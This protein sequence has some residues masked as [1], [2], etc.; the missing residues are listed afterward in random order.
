MIVDPAFDKYVADK[1]RSA[2]GDDQTLRQGIKFNRDALAK[3]LPPQ[4]GALAAEALPS[5]PPSPVPPRLD[6][7]QSVV[8]PPDMAKSLP[9]GHTWGKD[10]RGIQEASEDDQISSSPEGSE[11]DD[12]LV[13][14]SSCKRTLFCGICKEPLTWSCWIY[15]LSINSFDKSNLN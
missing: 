12:I 8:V 14:S 13:D 11:E 10:V 6:D 3:D 5:V 15:C 2:D 7:S 9:W 1:V 4:S